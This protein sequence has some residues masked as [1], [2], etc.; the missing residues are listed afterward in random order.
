M[1]AGVAAYGAC[2]DES[3]DASEPDVMEIFDTQAHDELTCRVCGALVARAEP[4]PR[5]HWDWHEAANGA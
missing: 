2:M 3:A 1:A 4:W 5:T